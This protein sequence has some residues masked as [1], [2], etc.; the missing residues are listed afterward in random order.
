MSLSSVKPDRLL[1]K[2]FAKVIADY[3]ELMGGP[4]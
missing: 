4:A 2:G 1:D 3:A